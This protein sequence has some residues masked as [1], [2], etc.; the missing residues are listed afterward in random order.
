MKC[1]MRS[2]LSWACVTSV[3]LEKHVLEFVFL[4]YHLLY[5]Q[6]VPETNI[7]IK[8]NGIKNQKVN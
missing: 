7:A 3:P 5:N 4:F 2:C 6:S 1:P 8:L